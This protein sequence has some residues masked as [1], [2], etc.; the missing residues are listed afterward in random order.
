MWKFQLPAVRLRSANR[1]REISL[2]FL[3]S[4]GFMQTWCGRLTRQQKQNPGTDHPASAGGGRVE[5]WREGGGGGRGE[6]MEN[7]RKSSCFFNPAVCCWTKCA[8]IKHFY[9]FWF[10]LERLKEEM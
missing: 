6:R 8:V 1:K 3:S 5:G 10:L 4:H 9:L 7:E 2:E